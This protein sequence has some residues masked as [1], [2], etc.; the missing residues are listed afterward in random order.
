MSLILVLV[1]NVIGV[2]MPRV[3]IRD[4]GVIGGESCDR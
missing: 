4:S 3:A 1:S 2:Y